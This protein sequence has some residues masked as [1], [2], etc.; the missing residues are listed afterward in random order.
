M[1]T[2]QDFRP[3]PTNLFD[4]FDTKFYLDCLMCK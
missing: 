2:S 3:D 4:L 1:G